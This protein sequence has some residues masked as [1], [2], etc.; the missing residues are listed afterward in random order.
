MSAMR[1]SSRQLTGRVAMVTGGAGGICS[2]L[3]KGLASAGACV[4]LADMDAALGKKAESE[5]RQMGAEANFRKVD[6]SDGAAVE[7]L[8]DEI[9]K[10]SGRIDI[11][12]NGAG[13][14]ARKSVF[15]L[16]LAEWNRVLAVNLTGTFLCS[17]AAAR[18]MVGAGY[19]RII[20]V[21]AI[22]ATSRPSPRNSPYAVSK[23]GINVFTQSLAA[24]LL[25]LKVDV[26]INAI[27]PATVDTP[28][29]RKDRS[30]EQIQKTLASG[31]VAQPDDLLG[32]LLF[33]ASPES[34]AISGQIIGHKNY[35]FSETVVNPE[36]PDFPPP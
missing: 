18:R 31:S 32:L 34:A 8:V 19:G 13:T 21:T 36:R 16:T 3:A 33:L 23:A 22:N 25:K 9:C 24:E 2:M 12:L 10:S 11:L 17:Q 29:Y 27:S 14:A 4:W 28:F 35:M 1:N 20:S 15:E 30:M 6:V 26:T 5:L 7:N